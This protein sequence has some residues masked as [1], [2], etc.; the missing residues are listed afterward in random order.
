MSKE[1]DLLPWILGGLLMATAAVAIA[2]GAANRITANPAPRQAVTPAP[3]SAPVAETG[4][5]PRTMAALVDPIVTPSED[6]ANSLPEAALAQAAA[7]NDQIWQCVTQGVKTF[8]NNPCGDKSALLEVGPVNTMN[9]TPVLHYAQAYAPT[10][11]SEPRYSQPDAQTAGYAEQDYPD[12]VGRDNYVVVQGFAFPPR[13]YPQ[14]PHR[15]PHHYPIWPQPRR[16]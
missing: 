13:R 14:H 5:A 4:T 11:T 16:N 12:P 3:I 2:I 7:P 9:P 8:S 1:R 15:P 10:Y 6:A